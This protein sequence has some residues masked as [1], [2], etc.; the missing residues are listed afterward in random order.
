MRLWRF[1]HREIKDLGK[2][3]IALSAAFALLYSFEG[4][5]SIFSSSLPAF[6]FS[7]FI[8]FFFIS[9]FTVGVG[10]LFHEL[11]HKAVA[12]KY[13]ARAEFHSFDAMLLIAIGMSFFGF[14]LAAPGAVFIHGRLSRKENGKISAAGP[15]VNLLLG[16]IFLVLILFFGNNLFLRFGFSI[17]AWLALFN[18]IPLMP[19]DGAKVWQWSKSV[20]ILIVVAA[21]ILVFGI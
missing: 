7:R 11:A 8:I 12:Q 2:A 15:M 20:Y 16:I 19:L 17:N 18:M 3:W 4:L 9:L 6:Q 14:L 10:F 1:S 5:G 21:L 13:G